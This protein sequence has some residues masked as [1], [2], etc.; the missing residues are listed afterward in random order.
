MLSKQQIGEEPFKVDKRRMNSFGDVGIVCPDKCISEIIGVVGEYVVLDGVAKRPQV[1]YREDA[2]RARIAFAECMNLPDICYESREMRYG[3]LWGKSPVGEIAL[4]LKLIFQR[5]GNP[6]RAFIANG[7]LLQY[8]FAFGDVV[9]ANLPGEL[10][11]T[12]K[13]FAVD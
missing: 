8:P 13:E 3:L 5:R 9:V 7:I 6:F 4:A 11:Y 12:E 1:L 2:R 10:V